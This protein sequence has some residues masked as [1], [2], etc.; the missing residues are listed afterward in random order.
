M[1]MQQNDE[2]QVK[3]LFLTHPN[4]YKQHLHTFIRKN[5]TQI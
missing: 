2:F 5:H 1:I 4:A 3:I